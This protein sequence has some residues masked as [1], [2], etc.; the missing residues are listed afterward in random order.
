M[1]PIS[2]SRLLIIVAFLCGCILPASNARAQDWKDCE[3]RNWDQVIRGCTAALDAGNLN[4]ENE[5]RAYYYRGRAHRKKGDYDPAIKDLTQAIA[6]EPAASYSHFERGLAFKKKGEYESAIVD[7]TEAIRL[8][9]SEGSYNNRGNVYSELGQ[10]DRA[11]AD[12]DAALKLNP[13]DALARKNRDLAR[14][15]K[16]AAAATA[17]PAPKKP[18][19]ST[20]ECAPAWIMPNSGC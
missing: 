17:A 15:H 18:V 16:S 13:S 5:A 12:F 11:I 19:L 10:Y 20:T 8:K 14:R 3:S 6:L 4:K 1:S 2:I 9:P 7:Y